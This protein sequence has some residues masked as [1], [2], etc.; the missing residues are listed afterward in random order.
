MA[1]GCV[2]AFLLGFLG[3]TQQ[4]LLQGSS[5][6]NQQQFREA[7]QRDDDCPNCGDPAPK[8]LTGA[9]KGRLL[10]SQ[11]AAGRALGRCS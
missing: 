10:H 5:S 9:L 11:A 7:K 3:A 1:P 4:R 2:M 6:K 8:S